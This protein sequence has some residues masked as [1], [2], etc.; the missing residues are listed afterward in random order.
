MS[1]NCD[2]LNLPLNTPM[3]PLLL[4]MAVAICDG[5]FAP[6]STFNTLLAGVAVWQ[7]AHETVKPDGIVL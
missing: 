2:A 4:A 3:P 1:A 7:V 6:L 5:S